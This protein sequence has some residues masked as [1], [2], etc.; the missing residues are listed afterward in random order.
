VYPLGA[1]IF[2]GGTAL[3][4][5]FT[6]WR[7]IG[8]VLLGCVLVALWVAATPIFANWLNWQLA[9]QFP[10]RLPQR[11]VVILLGGWSDGRIIYA[12][13]IYRVGKAPR[14][15]I[16][17]GNLPWLRA[18]VPEAER[19]ADLLV[20]LD[21]PRSAVILETKSLNTRENALNTAAIFKEHGWRNGLLVTSGNHMPRALAAFKKV[22]VDVTAAPA[23][24]PARPLRLDSPL[25]LLPDAGAL[26]WTTS[27]IK[28]MIGL[29]IYRYRGWA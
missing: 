9:S 22:G 7:R 21:V 4:L 19:I 25:D 6:G 2:I 27:G 8:Q 16:S 10:Q 20:D 24:A 26:A 12:L 28:E 17:G 13:Q 5:C 18:K 29:Y 3:A 14:I 23:D 15:L 11:D 1:A